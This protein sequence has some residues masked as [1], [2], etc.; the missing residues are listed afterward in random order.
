M[1]FK[2]TKIKK[3]N[4][5]EIAHIDA[6]GETHVFSGWLSKLDNTM[7]I[8]VFTFTAYFSR[9]IWEGS[10]ISSFVYLITEGSAVS[11][12]SL[13]GTLG[14]TQ[15]FVAPIMGFLSDIMPRT[16]ILS[17]ASVI[18]FFATFLTVY[19]V[20][21][22]EY[23]RLLHCM[24]V[25][26]F[27][28]GCT[29]PCI[30]ALLADSIDAGKRSEAYTFRSS[31][32]N[33]AT[34]FGPL[35][36]SFLFYFVGDHWRLKEI[37]LVMTIG[38]VLF[39][40]PCIILFSFHFIKKSGDR[41]SADNGVNFDLLCNKIRN[42]FKGKEE[43][44]PKSLLSRFNRFSVFG[45]AEQISPLKK[46]KTISNYKQV[47]QD[48]SEMDADVEM[49][50][51][52]LFDHSPDK[53]ISDTNNNSSDGTTNN[54]R[55]EAE[56]G[57]GGGS[58]IINNNSS[59]NSSSGSSSTSSSCNSIIVTDNGSNDI[60]TTTNS[61]KKPSYLFIASMI[62]GGDVITGLASGMTIKFFPI[63]FMTILRLSPLRLSLLYFVTPLMT[64]LFSQGT[65]KL[66]LL[67]GR[68]FATLFVK[69]C[70]ISLLILLAAL[71][72]HRETITSNSSNLSTID[73]FILFVFVLRTA[74]MN[75][76]KGLTKSIIM[77]IVPKDQRG[78]WNALESINNATFSGS[79]ILGGY[80]VEKYGFIHNFLFTAG[81]QFLA[82]FPLV[83]IRNHVN[84]EA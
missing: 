3:M 70:G 50:D 52:G 72:V 42:C 62:A 4:S 17:L 80:L 29:T 84:N 10:I 37:Q 60:S 36:A 24:V 47:L 11:I 12:G 8:Y 20:R 5:L 16:W 69:S 75:C 82:M 51:S 53:S 57:G 74:S 7:F 56:L 6:S 35:L 32:L 15:I 67:W 27:F 43:K 77:D 2:W 71:A 68:I 73:N 83:I 28:W 76:S 65:Q 19:A 54:N 45:H 63:F 13:S 39:I 81:L 34:S 22:G 61:M 41:S 40:V 18:G 48:D 23:Y 55:L 46:V 64:T 58:S 30:D 38:L 31:L 59:N 25:W 21:S 9:A 14:F 49:I 78:R 1:F 44:A 66:G 33:V 79:A 26:G